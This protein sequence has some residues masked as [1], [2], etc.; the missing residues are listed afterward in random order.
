[1]LEACIIDVGV[2]GNVNWAKIAA[3]MGQF[4]DPTKP[5][6]FINPPGISNAT[7]GYSYQLG[8]VVT[9]SDSTVVW[10]A[11]KGTITGTG[12]VMRYTSPDAYSPDGDTI[13]ARLLDDPSVS[14]TIKVTL[15]NCSGG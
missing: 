4:I 15:C 8:A 13:T 12:N 7:L 11:A 2:T 5:S 3:E 10:T 14:F 6:I 1:L 9:G